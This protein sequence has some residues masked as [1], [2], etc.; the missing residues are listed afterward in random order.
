MPLPAGSQ[1]PGVKHGLALVQTTALPGVQM[2]AWQ[3]SP[4]VQLLLSLQGSPFATGV[5]PTQVPDA[6]LHV[7][8]ERQGL[9]L[10]QITGLVPTHAPAW[11][12][13]DCVQALLSLQTVPL[14]TGT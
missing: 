10:V 14:A 5:C 4:S 13:S 11:Q 6:G 8:P 9:A 12:T 3:A 1:K 2:P 7:P